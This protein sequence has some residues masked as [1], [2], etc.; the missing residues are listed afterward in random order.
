MFQV[1][2]FKIQVSGVGLVCCRW[3]NRIRPVFVFA[4]FILDSADARFKIQVS[5]F[6]FQDSGFKIQVS[7]KLLP[8]IFPCLEGS[9]ERSD[10][11]LGRSL[12]TTAMAARDRV[13]GLYCMVS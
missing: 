11:S 6:R 4:I 13:S 10:G 7:S 8:N 3:A 1:S 12:R 9:T 2:S 5:R